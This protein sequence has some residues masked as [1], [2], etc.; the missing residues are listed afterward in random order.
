MDGIAEFVA[1]TVASAD[2]LVVVFVEHVVVIL[3][4][5]DGYH[6]LT[7]IAFNLSVDA[8]FADTADEGGKDLTQLVGE[9]FCLFVFYTGAFG[10]GGLLLH[11]GAVFAVVLVL[12]GF[13]GVSSLQVTLQQAVYH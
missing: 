12:V 1:A 3:E 13:D 10:I 8:P 7:L 2:N 9:V 5:T 11:D 4:A 6:A